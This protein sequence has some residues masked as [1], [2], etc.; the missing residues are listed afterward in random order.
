MPLFGTLQKFYGILWVFHLMTVTA[1]L[2]DS[3]WSYHIF[4][5]I[6]S[7]TLKYLNFGK[8]LG[9]LGSSVKDVTGLHF[10]EAIVNITEMDK[11]YYT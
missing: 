8:I 3:I 2:S 6:D 7:L 4:S 11:I 9:R 5:W 10:T 1:Y